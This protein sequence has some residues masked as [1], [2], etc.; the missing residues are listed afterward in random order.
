[1]RSFVSLAF[2]D[3]DFMG[4]GKEPVI[5]RVWVF[6]DAYPLKVSRE[7]FSQDL[8][9]DRWMRSSNGLD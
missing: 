3:L 8:D 2:V 7:Q 1:M 5:L 4:L 6:G 9:L